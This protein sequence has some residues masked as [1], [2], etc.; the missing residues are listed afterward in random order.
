MVNGIGAYSSQDLFAQEARRRAE[1]YAQANYAQQAGYPNQGAM[2]DA[3]Y[4]QYLDEMSLM[5][6]QQLQNNQQLQ[7]Q[8]Q[9]QQSQKPEGCTDGKD[10]GKI[11]F[12]QGVKHL[13]K[14]VKNI[15]AGFIGFDKD[16]NWSAGRL[17][18]NLAVGTAIAAL[19]F[20]TWGTAIPSIVTAYG[21]YTTGMGLAKSAYQTFTVKTDA[22]KRSALE[23]L[24]ANLFAFT[25]AV[26]GAKAAKVPKAGTVT[27]P[28]QG[29]MG[30]I[31]SGWNDFTNFV[32]HPTSTIK[33]AWN[34]N[35]MIVKNNWKTIKNNWNESSKQLTV[36][37]KQNKQIKDLETKINEFKAKAEVAKGRDKAKYEAQVRRLEARKADIASAYDEIN[38]VTSFSQAQNKK[39][40]LEQEIV[41]T[42][43]K[44]SNTTNR[45]TKTNLNQEL[46]VLEAKLEVYN[47]V[48]DQKVS[49]GRNI[50]SELESIAKKEADG[51]G[52][53]QLT[54]R[55]QE[56]IN[57]ERQLKFELPERATHKNYSDKFDEADALVSKKQELVDKTKAEYTEAQNAY[58]KLNKPGD[59]S[60]E[61]LAAHTA[62]VDAR[63]AY[64]TAIRELQ[65]AKI[66]KNLYES[67]KTASSGCDYVGTA[68][69][70][71]S[72]SYN[73]FNNTLKEQYGSTTLDI[74]FAN[75]K[76]PFTNKHIPSI[77]GKTFGKFTVPKVS[78]PNHVIITGSNVPNP[79]VGGPSIEEM[80]LAEM[81]MTPKQVDEFYKNKA[82]LDKLS[83]MYQHQG[84]PQY[85]G[86]NSYYPQ[87]A[88]QTQG[89]N[90]NDIQKLDASMDMLGII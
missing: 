65:Q 72:K 60:A 15:C 81:G 71:L 43:N 84:F 24:G 70:F 16:G 29:F 79:S 44:L 49:L 3:M 17:A 5:Q 22:Q 13:A 52:S 35:A 85:T 78:I 62:E 11:G 56:L 55:K 42:Q 37:E 7:P 83:A 9:A 23:D 21:I 66:Q 19:C 38:N 36:Q 80:F 47:R 28:K 50:R 14:G 63:Y 1:A 8:Q 2:Q 53:A 76:I 34:K 59:Q 40:A 77:S 88:Q 41:K 69:A 25:G 32:K 86:Y 57:Q 54:A 20:F 51:K 31:K 58:N 82:E 67:Y 61:R 87:A 45:I 75:A 74:P 18:K 4:Q 68:K 6:A 12:W 64:R 90:F 46:S 73:T 30:S 26:I 48:I 39:V 27:T 89:V 33:S 10:D